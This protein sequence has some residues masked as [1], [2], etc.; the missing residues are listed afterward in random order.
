MLEAQLLEFGRIILIALPKT[1]S[2][3]KASQDDDGDVPDEA[4]ETRSQGDV[5]CELIHDLTDRYGSLTLGDDG[6]QVSL[7][8]RVASTSFATPPDCKIFR[9][10]I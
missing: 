10:P 1:V 4:D 3:L 6:Q 9:G 5:K 2:W 8:R 7:A